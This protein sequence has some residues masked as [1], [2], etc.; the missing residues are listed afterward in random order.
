MMDSISQFQ[1]VGAGPKLRKIAYKVLPPA[2][3]S[4]PTVLWLIG[5]KSDM[6]STKAEALAEWCAG[7]GFGLTR[8]DYSGHG[9]SSGD[10]VK[11]TIGDWLEE[12]EAIFRSHTGSGPVVLVGSSTGAH[13]ALL[14]LRRLI[15]T[16]SAAADRVRGLM[17]IAPAWDVTDLIWRQLPDSAKQEVMDKG[18]HNQPSDYGEPYQ[19]TRNFIEE[20]R[21]HTFAGSTFDPGRP[22]FVLQGLQDESVPYQHARALAG[23]LAG[24]WLHITEV[25]DGEHRLSRPQDLEKIFELVELAA[26]PPDAA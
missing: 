23:V 10:F 19:I 12:A 7:N 15:E 5:L 4:A 17:L 24:D 26:V 22:V 2:T 14:L 20:G 21:K 8:F 18:I 6:I 16:N 13:I 9:Q 25:A 1:D 3:S 11:A